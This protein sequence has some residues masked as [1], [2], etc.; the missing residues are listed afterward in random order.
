[1]SQMG[2]LGGDVSISEVMNIVCK[3]VGR[4]EDGFLQV[5]PEVMDVLCES[6]ECFEGVLI[7]NLF[8]FVL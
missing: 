5:I 4:C 2:V 7:V 8:I 1:M 6:D 3:S